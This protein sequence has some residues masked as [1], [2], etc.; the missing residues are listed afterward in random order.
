MSK[1]NPE[2]LKSWE[3]VVDQIVPLGRASRTAND[4]AVKLAKLRGGGSTSPSRLRST[5][6]DLRRKGHKIPPLAAFL[7][8]PEGLGPL[9]EAVAERRAGKAPTKEEQT[10]EP[11]L[12][13][14]ELSILKERRKASDAER[15]KQEAVRRL[16]LAEERIRVALAIADPKAP[17]RIKPRA[18]IDKRVATAVALASDWHVEE[19]VDP[20]TV[21]GRNE[22]NPDIAKARS[23]EF[24]EA[25]RWNVKHHSNGYDIREIILWLGGD[26]ITGYIHEELMESNFLSPVQAVIYAQ[27]MFIEGIDYLLSE[28]WEII[29]PCNYGNHGRTTEK[30]RVQTGA[31]NS[32][33]WLMYQTL[34]K[35]YAGNDRVKFHVAEGSH[36]YLDV[37]D[38]TVRFH[39]GDDVRFWGG[40]GGLSIPLRKSI[41]AWNEF[42]H[43]DLTCIGH[44]H[45]YQDFRDCVVNGSLIGYNAYALSIKA[46]FEK[47][48]QAFFLIDQKYGK[49]QASPIHLGD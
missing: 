12:H 32:Y 41:D 48:I 37:Y 13:P 19:R 3:E 30:R 1:K 35:H 26:L 29:I 17:P 6:V 9:A 47:P 15:A 11:P 31:A 23:R 10:E 45:S 34:A 40:V 21:N 8:I 18:R 16:D 7:G 2:T 28:G 24:F 22:Y 20:A 39:H 43:A 44:F 5:L 46:R 38:W 25:V 14:A 36:I 33:E 4:L 42:K 49:T 27:Q